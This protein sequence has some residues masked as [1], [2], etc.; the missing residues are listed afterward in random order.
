[1][2]DSRRHFHKKDKCDRIQGQRTWGRERMRKTKIIAIEGIDGG[3]K[4]VQ[5]R[6]LKENLQKLGYTV[7]GRDYPMYDTYFGAQV[8]KLLSG[9]DGVRA[10]EID[11]KS[12]A[13]WFALDRWESFKDYRD[14]ETDFLIINRFVLSNAVYQSIRDIDLGKPDIVNWVMDLEYG[15]FGL[16]KPDLNIVFSILPKTAEENVT[17]KGYRGYVGE[18]K[19]VYEADHGIQQRAMEK[20]IEIATDMEDADIIY[21]MEE[22]R[23]KSIDDIAKMVM[24]AIKRR[25]LI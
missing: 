18:G 19:D 17:K 9:A 10:D 13:L 23:L 11:G 21:C 7:A 3:G 5:V 20:Y 25:G 2:V 6:A 14:G 12:M 8:G 24:D 16:P 1:M 15:H 4:G 22:G